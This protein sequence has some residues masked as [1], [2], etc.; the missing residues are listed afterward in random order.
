MLLSTVA[1][2]LVPVR[3]VPCNRHIHGR[4]LEPVAAATATATDDLQQKQLQATE[5]EHHV[6]IARGRSLFGVVSEGAS[7]S[8]CAFPDAE[9]DTHAVER[10]RSGPNEAD[11]RGGHLLHASRSPVINEADCAAVIAE[12]RT[13]MA[14]G[15]T[16]RFT[17]TAA[18]R[19][20]EVHVS[21]LPGARRW[22]SERIADTFW[23]L[24]ESRYG[25]RDGESGGQAVRASELAVYDALVIKYDA[26]R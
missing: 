16:S 12:A 8:R 9:F 14:S 17:Y 7:S 24:L 18:S 11:L 19:I 20:A 2:A 4:S 1:L 10:G 21:E 25:A 26:A 22:L 6:E 15:Q 13:A 5:E 3:F 23:P